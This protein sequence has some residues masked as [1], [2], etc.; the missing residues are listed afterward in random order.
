MPFLIYIARLSATMVSI[1]LAKQVPISIRIFQLPFPCRQMK[2]NTNTGLILGF[3]LASERRR[4][5][6]T[7]SLIGWAQT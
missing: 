2:D 1:L 5:N 4:Y 7:P 3:R 6:V